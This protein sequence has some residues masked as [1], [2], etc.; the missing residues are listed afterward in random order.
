[1]RIS[2]LN[3]DFAVSPQ[4][5]YEDVKAIAKA[6]FVTVINNR[7]DGEDTAQPLSKA[8]AKACKQAG[9]A[10]YHIPFKPGR[11]TAQDREKFKT[12]L[13]Q[14]TGPVLAFCRSGMRARGLYKSIHRSPGLLSKLFGR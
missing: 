4:I 5:S 3:S 6:G 1:M 9:I 12:A 10:Y 2:P 11:A 7:P 8:L 14:S 13:A